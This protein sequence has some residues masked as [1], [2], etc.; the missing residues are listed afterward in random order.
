MNFEHFAI[1]VSDIEQ[2][3]Q[4]YVAH[5]GL[6]IVKRQVEPPYMTFLA[7]STNRVV[8]ELYHRPDAVI[9]D[10]GQQH[11]LT[12][13]IA[14]VSQNAEEDKQ[15]LLAQGATYFEEVNTDDGSHLVMLRDPWGIPLQLCQRTEAF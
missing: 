11:P 3:V 15:R 12:F 7:D 5:I 4:W 1:N 10:F 6:K 9:T 2:T 13:H 8:V 14:F